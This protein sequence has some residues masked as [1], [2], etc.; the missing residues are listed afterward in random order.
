MQRSVRS[1]DAKS[2]GSKKPPLGEIRVAEFF[3]HFYQKT[4]DTISIVCYNKY[5]KQ[6]KGTPRKERS[7]SG[8]KPLLIRVLKC[9]YEE[10]VG[11]IVETYYR[12]SNGVNFVTRYGMVFLANGDYEEV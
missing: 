8:H 11:Q 10:F 3:T 4:I 6:N 12:F 2:F 9:D 1:A 5:R 7:M